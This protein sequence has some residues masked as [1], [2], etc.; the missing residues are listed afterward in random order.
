MSRTLLYYP[1][2]ELPSSS[3]LKTSLLY[4]DE[5]GSIVPHRMGR[6][7]ETPNLKYLLGEGIYKRFDPE[8]YL[9]DHNHAKNFTD[10]FVQRLDAPEFKA[11]MMRNDSGQYWSIAFEKMTYDAWT[12]LKDK[13]LA[14]KESSMDGWVRVKKPAAIIYMGLLAKALASNDAEY[15]QPSTD[16]IDYEDI[17]YRCSA[18]QSPL[19]G[20]ALSL[21]RLL[22][23]VSADTSLQSVIE[24]RRSRGDE[25]LRFRQL[26]D[27]C[28]AKISKCESEDEA[29]LTLTQFMEK[30]ELAS[31]DMKR[32]MEEKGIRYTVG[33]MRAIFGAK[34]PAWLAGG[35]AGLAG[36][37]SFNP[38]V[39]AVAAVGG[40]VAG[41]SVEVANYLLDAKDKQRS[42]LESPFS[43]LYSAKVDKII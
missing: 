18:I 21:K 7:L 24:F 19:P 31:S 38:L 33:I 42:L 35:A 27:E 39:I 34:S 3:W 22:P 4:W 43:Y 25:L 15:V 36:S 10:E 16:N 5:V 14:L 2:F 41:G 17:I 6:V 32:V 9:N 28:Q 12:V 11:E 8:P 20:I 26:V 29:K 23:K 40:F 37:L 1:T 30:Y 13:D